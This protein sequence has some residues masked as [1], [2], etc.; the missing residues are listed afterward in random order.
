M[1]YLDVEDLLHLAERVLDAVAGRIAFLGVN[2][3]R[4]TMS[5]DEAYDLIISIASGELD[6]VEAI[7]RVLR[8]HTRPRPRPVSG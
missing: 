3:L 4:V 1:I 2:G 8:R 6:D 5:E 7:A